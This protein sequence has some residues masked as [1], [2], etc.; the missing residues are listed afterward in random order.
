MYHRVGSAPAGTIVPGH[1]VSPKSFERHLKLLR[2]RG[3]ASVSPAES[4]EINRP[5]VL[6]TFDDGYADFATA[7][8]P[9]LREAGFTAIVF[10]CTGL[11]GDHNAWDVANG[12]VR[13]PLMDATT[14]SDLA[15]QGFWFGVH[16]AQHADLTAVPETRFD[17]EIRHPRR[18]LSELIGAEVDDFCYP[19]GRHSNTVRQAVAEAG[20]RRGFATGRGIPG[21]PYA[22]GRINVRRDTTALV[23]AYKL[24]RHRI[25]GGR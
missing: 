18:R 10:V 7:A 15:K 21:D 9:R 13:E 3:L 5:G 4:Q 19:Y 14:I 17:R 22:I 23:L 1:Y 25:R 6:L 20:Y 16:T 11:L 8:A 24:L 12:D 2:A